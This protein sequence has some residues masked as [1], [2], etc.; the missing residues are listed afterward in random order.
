MILNLGNDDFNRN[1]FDDINRASDNFDTIYEQG[2]RDRHDRAV[3]DRERAPRRSAARR[4][5]DLDFTRAGERGAKRQGGAEKPRG[6]AGK[7]RRRRNRLLTAVVC[8]VTVA[9][10]GLCGFSVLMNSK[11]M[12][13]ADVDRDE[14][15]QFENIITSSSE[16]VSYFLVCGVDLSE[17]LTDI[18]MVACFDHKNNKVNVLQIPRDSYVGP[19][20]VSGKINSVYETARE[21]ESRIKALIRCINRDF[22]L[23]IDHYATVTIGGAE[24]IIDIAGG[25]DIRLERD[26]RLVDDT[27]DYDVSKYFEA[28]DVH[29]DGKWGTAF[30]RHRAS[31][32]AGD[33]QRVNAQR[34]FYAAFIK[35]MLSLDMNRMLEIVSSCA[36]EVSTDLT[37]GEM[38]G[39]AKQLRSLKL[40]DV[41][42]V[43]VPGE[44]DEYNAPTGYAS[45]FSVYTDELCDLLNSRFR[46]YE[47]SELTVD[48][49]DIPELADEHSGDYDQLNSEDT[50]DNIDTFK[51]RDDS[52]S[53]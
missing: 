23:P 33:P 20:Y 28:G 10:L 29:F 38:L 52:D 26:F 14:H 32:D 16:D 9:A 40:S 17:N 36:G 34:K 7:S 3:Y 35:K 47:D 51:D 4:S 39:Y 8:L 49:L 27:G 13:N 11:F 18:I 42:I 6:K 37:L 43:T 5:V 21:G 30:I 25:V 12:R 41:S 31:Y 48:D 15:D 19:E 24:K 45:Y 1:D 53:N 2:A 50:L 44:S 46:P 22:G